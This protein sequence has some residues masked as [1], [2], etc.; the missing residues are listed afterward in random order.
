MQGGGSL[1]LM[2]HV[3]TPGQQHLQRLLLGVVRGTN[4]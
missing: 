2:S 1:L 4:R 3:Q